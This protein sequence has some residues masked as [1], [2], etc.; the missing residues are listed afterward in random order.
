MKKGESLLDTV[1]TIEAMGIDAIVVRH[2]RGRRAAPRRGVDR[3][4]RRQRGRRPPRAPDAGAAR[5]VHAAPPPRPVARRL[6]RRD[7][8]RHPQLA[9]RPQQRARRSHALG[10]ER[11][12]RRA[13]HADARAAR[14]LAG[15][16]LL[17]PRRR[18]RPTSTSSTCCASSTSASARRCSRRSAST[19]ARW[20]LTAERAA[21]LKPDTLVMHPGPDE[22]R[23]RDR[24]RGRRLGRARS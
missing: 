23:R 2:A 10:C 16:R 20:G 24:G 5:R 17:R 18:A 12:A 6:P 1:Q 13:A 21:R 3:R 14:R 11:H 9:R 22:P 15:H 8:R 7:R 4:E 19:R